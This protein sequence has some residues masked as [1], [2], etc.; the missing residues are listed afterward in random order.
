MSCS[1]TAPTL[2]TEAADVLGALAP[3]GGVRTP[4]GA[5]LAEA[6]GLSAM[7]PPGENERA[8]VLEALGPM[9]VGVDE[10]IRQTGLSAAQIAM[11]LLELD[12]A[13]RPGAP[14]RRECV[15]DF[16]RLLKALKE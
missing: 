4:R 2:V 12:L 3:L 16:R 6:P 1:R 11:V 13:G 10:I 7:P 9:P 14:S 5:P 8:D 15:A